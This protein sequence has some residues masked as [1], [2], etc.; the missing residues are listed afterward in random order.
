[1]KIGLLSDTHGYLDERIFDYFSDRDEIWHAG[2]IGE[3]AIIEKLAGFKMT[4]AVFGNIDGPRIRNSVPEEL[5]FDCSGLNIWMT[6]IAGY[7]PRYTHEIRRRLKDFTP[8][9]LVCGHSHILRI[10]KDQ[11]FPNL[12][13][14]NPGAAGRQGFHRK[15]TIIRFEIKSGHL[16]NVQVIELG[17]RG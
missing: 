6:H 9:L 11:N 2:D 4:R 12:T 17:D 13:F 3:P 15:R 16:G 5:I 10:I 8:N 7:P 1:M 14:M